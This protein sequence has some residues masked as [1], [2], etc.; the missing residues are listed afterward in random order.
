MDRAGQLI[1]QPDSERCHL[2]SATAGLATLHSLCPR[3]SPELKKWYCSEAADPPSKIHNRLPWC[4]ASR[5]GGCGG[6]GKGG[7]HMDL[8]KPCTHQQYSTESTHITTATHTHTLEQLYVIAHWHSWGCDTG[9]SWIA[10]SH[11]SPLPHTQLWGFFMY[12]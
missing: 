7:Y 9:E 8:R 1:I 11:T 12:N 2:C 3:S 10:C 6:F 5:G 4:L